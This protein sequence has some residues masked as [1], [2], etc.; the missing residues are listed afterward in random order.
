MNGS[1]HEIAIDVRDLTRTFG[2]FTAVDRVRFEVGRGEIFGFLGANGAGKSTTIRMLCGLLAPTAGTARVGGYDVVA[3]PER[4]KRTIG[5]MSQRFSLY[6]DLTVAE[7]LRFF[8]RAYGLAGGA[9]RRRMGWALETVGLTG[10]EGRMTGTLSVG[11]KQRLALAS[12]VLHEPR[13]VFLDEP[14]GGVDPVARR[15]FWDLIHALSDAGVTVLVTTH[16]L[17]EAEY[18]EHIVLLQAG[19]VIADGSPHALKTEHIT[20]LLFEVV[21]SD[22][23]AALERLP[24]R[25]E[26]REVSL[27]GTR[28][29]VG[30]TLDDERRAATWLRGFLEDAGLTV[31][32]AAPIVPTLE[33]VFI[34]LNQDGSGGGDAP[35]GGEG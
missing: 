28:L 14:T 29:H 25:P 2:G 17:D 35:G 7:N 11:W 27:F 12:A 34:Y 15:R 13:I 1:N 6:E 21:C 3:E 31:T 24:G 23:V 18:C 10:H 30:L 9:L 26:V 19:R 22:P 16:Y 8:G 32:S 5:Y 4:V 20:G 33:D